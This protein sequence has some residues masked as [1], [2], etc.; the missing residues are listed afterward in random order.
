[1]KIIEMA[2]IATVAVLVVGCSTNEPTPN[3][4]NEIVTLENGKQYSVPAGAIYTK[5]PVTEKAIA[6]Y[7]E[8]GV[9]GCENGDITWEDK[10]V[11]ESINSIM[12]NGTKEEGVSIIQKAAK[13][14]TIGCAS[15]LPHA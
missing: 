8:L 5:A 9:K 12:R 13:E 6:R 11:S 10:S 15:A 1:M 7:T 4:K 14:G 3:T 2:M